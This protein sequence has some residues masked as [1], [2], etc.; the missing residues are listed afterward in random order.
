MT[1]GN[2]LQVRVDLGPRSYPILIGPGTRS[3][4]TQVTRYRSRNPQ[5]VVI[6]D[7]TV[8]DLHGMALAAALPNPPLVVT[9]DPGE[10][11][12]TLA[13]CQRIQEAL[14]AARIE[15][16]AVLLTFGGGVAGD[17][18][19]FV[20]ATWL[21]G[22]AYVQVPTT[23]LAAID[24]SVGG[25]TG[26]NLTAGKNL[27]GAFHQPLAVVVDLDFLATLPTRTYTAGLAES[28]KHALI[29][30]A[31]L[32]AW[33]ERNADAITARAPDVLAELIARNCAIKAAVVAADEREADLRAI[34]NF[35]HTI[36]HALE[37]LLEYELQHGECVA[38]GML[39]ENELAQRRGLIDAALADRVRTLLARLGLPVRLPR[40]VAAV[41]VQQVCAV[42]KKTADGAVT[43]VL[44]RALGD[45][46]KVR[47]VT[48]AEIA[49]ALEVITP[50]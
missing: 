1:S 40:P 23:L 42:D 9:F 14:A 36:G 18:G 8:A 2:V 22:V 16:G 37:H 6:A 44:L 47:D 30:D 34:L 24:A 5:L 11:A 27:V 43:F 28:V 12:K 10:N 21:R 19:G 35:G 17:L 26:V 50:T 45:P 32:L 46:V 25:K 4:L 33:H 39:V 7:R 41:A 20:A 13:E 31:D 38:L 3:E 29:R 48:P 49:A 15:R